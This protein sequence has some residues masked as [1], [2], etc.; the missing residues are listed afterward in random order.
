M[1]RRPSEPGLLVPVLPEEK[2]LEDQF[3]IEILEVWRRGDEAHVHAERCATEAGEA[4]AR[5]I[6]RH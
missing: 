6:G 3:A 2:K 4:E 1:I 5:R